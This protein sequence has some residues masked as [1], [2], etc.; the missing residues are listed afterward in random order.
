[1]QQPVTRYVLAVDLGTSGAKVAL[2][3]STGAWPAGSS[4]PSS[5]SCCRAAARSSG[6][7]IGGGPWSPRRGDC[8][9]ATTVR[10][11]TVAAVCCSTQGE[12][13]V[14]VDEGGAPLTNC[15]LWMD[16]RGAP[17][18][19]RQFGGFPAMQ[20]ISLLKVRRWVKLTGGMPSPTGKDPAAHMLY[21]RDELPRG[22]RAHVQVPGRAGLPEPQAHR[23]HGRELRLDHDQLG[24]GQPRRGRREVRRRA[25]RATAASTRTSC[26]RS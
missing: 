15:L 24:D 20:G 8:S 22:V 11:L 7:T 23:A 3:G 4:R 5:C 16:M 14:P 18:L 25:G 1:M 6:R 12:G 19:R 10:P 13:T 26:R 21:I 2:S 17:H 9:P